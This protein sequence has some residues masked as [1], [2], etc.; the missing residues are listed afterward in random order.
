MVTCLSKIGQPVRLLLVSKHG[1]ILL[2][3]PE[4]LPE[5]QLVWCK[6]FSVSE[7][8]Q[9]ALSCQCCVP[10]S[11]VQSDEQL[12]A[13]QGEADSLGDPLQH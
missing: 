1:R 13:V 7:L 11:Q 3:C 10:A 4:V 6:A 2:T 9:T 12:A 5:P 8:Q